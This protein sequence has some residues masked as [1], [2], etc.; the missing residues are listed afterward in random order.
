MKRPHPAP[1]P[2]R[3]QDVGRAVEEL[4]PVSLAY[5]WDR[6]GLAVGAPSAEVSS[7]LFALTLTDEVVDA[8]GRA[9]AEMVVLH[10]PPIWEL[11][12]S[13][14]YD[15]PLTRPLL[16]LVR[17]NMACYSAHTNL[18]L[19]EG[20]V[21]DA[22]A[23]RLG[24]A[25]RGPLISAPQAGLRKLVAFV[26]ESHL[27]AV[28]DAVCT[29]GAGTI[30]AY[31]RC[32]FSAP[33]VGTFEPGA[34]AQPY[35]GEVGRLCEEPERRFET[36]VPAA[37]VDA[38]VDALLRAHPY[39]EAAYD[40]YTVEGTD[41]A[42]GLGRLGVLPKPVKLATF[43]EQVKTALKTPH[44]RYVGPPDRDVQCVGVI[45]GSGG[46][47]LGRV[48]DGVDVIVTGDVKYHDASDACR[49]GLAVVDAGH[50]ASEL[51]VLDVLEKR[52]QRALPGLRTACYE[53]P[54]LFRT[55]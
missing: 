35:A 40:V 17:L 32:T 22:L 19:A 43:A 23:D 34:G 46:S 9:G 15:D 44:V 49:R 1:S 13:I 41:P 45:G 26:P 2:W 31:T 3:V 11:L 37:R 54:E 14:R 42:V 51:P 7:V 38:A 30:G 21:N 6:S 39:E 48:P 12:R 16:A 24:L 50:A 47:E 8:A 25:V 29:A 4:A 55:T 36:L 28:R 5:S 20:G 18:D 10:H 27:D 52:V 53:E 33:G